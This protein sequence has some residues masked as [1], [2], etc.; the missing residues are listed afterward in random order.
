[1]NIF[2]RLP[3]SRLLLVCGLAIVIGISVTAL[4][5]ALGSGSTPPPKPLAEAVHDALSAPQVQGVS[6]NIKLTNHL[7]EGANLASGGGQGGEIASNPLIKGG[8]GRLWI[9]NDGRVRLELQ[10]EKGDTEVLYDGKTVTVY[11]GA[12][13]TLYRYTV[14]A[15]T[16]T[17]TPSGH[18]E[19]PTVAKIEEAISHISQHVNL[20]GAAPAEVAGQPA[21]TVR[22]SPKEGGSLIGGAELSFDSVHGVPLRAAI[23]STS[24]SAPVI[25]LAA[26]EISYGPVD[27]SVFA[28]TAPSGAKI[29][30]IKS[31]EGTGSDKTGSSSD[32]SKPTVTTH[33]KGLSSVA[34]VESKST[35]AQPSTSSAVEGLPKVDING[36]K[37]SE[38]RTALGTVLSFE[39]SGVRYVVGGAV[40][41]GSVEE[42]ARGL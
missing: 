5:S 1:V 35:G 24:S 33:G 21:Y 16:Q 11:D 34:V 27:S 37:A 41:P 14:P 6:A 25:E 22:V 42:I 12:T 3:L 28:F 30:E 2:R 40:T 39:R 29:D 13:N 18:H 17:D 20:S 26:S 36:T 15:G 19:V 10:A 7:L 31:S 23:Y 38:L 32:S 9:S 4:A 8:S